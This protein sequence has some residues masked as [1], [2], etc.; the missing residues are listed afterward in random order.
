MTRVP[1]LRSR[2]CD[3]RRVSHPR[4]LE[5]VPVSALLVSYIDCVV[6]EPSSASPLLPSALVSGSDANPSLVGDAAGCAPSVHH[7]LVNLLPPP[8]D[9]NCIVAAGQGKRLVARKCTHDALSLSATRQARQRH[10]AWLVLSGNYQRTTQWCPMPPRPDENVQLVARGLR[11]GC[12][13]CWRQ[14]STAASLR[15]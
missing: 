6:A 7:A 3:P 10:Q 12:R 2:P 11:L 1:S 13:S 9:S 15:T 8:T 4:L 5:G 14:R